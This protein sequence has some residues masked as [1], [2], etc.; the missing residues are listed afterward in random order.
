MISKS[1]QNRVIFFL[2]LDLFTKV[3]ISNDHNNYTIITTPYKDQ[4]LIYINPDK[5]GNGGR[6][7]IHLKNEDSILKW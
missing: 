3:K 2:F 7:K 1:L 4:G 6:D 5:D